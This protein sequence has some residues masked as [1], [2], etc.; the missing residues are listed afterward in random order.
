MAKLVI[1]TRLATPG[2]L[3]PKWKLMVQVSIPS[4]SR[5]AARVTVSHPTSSPTWM[6][7]FS[8]QR[9]DVCAQ[10]IAQCQHAPV[11]FDIAATV[12]GHLTP[13]TQQSLEGRDDDAQLLH[14]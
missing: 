5:V 11:V 4:G 10:L 7:P 14:A 8:K 3:R 1:M 6:Q 12:I 13:L 2:H 9:Q